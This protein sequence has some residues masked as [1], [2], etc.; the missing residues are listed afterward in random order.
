M[1]P[2]LYILS[3]E[4]KASTAGRSLFLS[5]SFFIIVVLTANISMN[6][7]G[8][9]ADK[10]SISILWIALAMSALLSVNMIFQND[11]DD[12]TLDWFMLSP[13]SL[14]TIV[15]LKAVAHWVTTCLP[16]MLLTPIACISMGI[17]FNSSLW[18]L[19]VMM[20]GTPAISFISTIGSAL[21][22]GERASHLLLP[23]FILPTFLPILVFG[24]KI[25]ML[26]TNSVYDSMAFLIMLAISLFC[27][28]ITPFITAMII[29]VHYT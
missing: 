16:I 6:Q 24:I 19:L 9:R 18:I 13:V 23:I 28:A 12:G 22:L 27:I 10:N 2:S 1:N 17:N 14:E 11:Y 5:T 4:I 7:F 15:I 29:K 26:V 20:I 25:S 21:T 3:Y 8:I